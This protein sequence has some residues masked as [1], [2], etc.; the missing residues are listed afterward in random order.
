MDPL[1]PIIDRARS[2]KGRIAFP[3]ATDPRTLA[4]ARRLMDENIVEPVLVG[5]PGSIRAA[6]ESAGVDTAGLPVE[7]PARAP[8]R[9]A[10]GEV[11]RLRFQGRSSEAA[12]LLDDPLYYAAGM[13]RAGQAAGTVAG[14]RHATAETVRAALR[15]IGPAPGVNTVSSLFLMALQRRT[16]GGEDLLAFADSGLVPDPDA[17]DLAEI[18]RWTASSYR[19]LTGR[20][21]RVALLS[22]STK[23]SADHPMVDKVRRAGE[24]LRR[25]GADFPFDDELQLDAAVV[26]EVARTKAPDSPLGGR[27]NVLIFPDLDAGNIG[28]KLVHRLAGARA[29]GPILQ[30]LAYPANDLSRGCDAE[31]IVVAAAVTAAQSLYVDGNDPA[32][33]GD[34]S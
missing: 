32:K 15:V 25:A 11:L 4:A 5:E 2:A 28:Y 13:V 34:P 17:E 9:A 7:C 26:P 3:E 30:G 10:V 19:Q 22:F 21:P 27:A 16:D 33:K 14:A 18:A 24:V 8:G 6:A 1:R 20:D 29:I 23:G 12:G 31:D